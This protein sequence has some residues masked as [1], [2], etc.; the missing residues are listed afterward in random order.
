MHQQAGGWVTDEKNK[1]GIAIKGAYA[2]ATHP[3]TDI[4][5]CCY[6]F[7]NE[8][9]VRYWTPAM[10]IPKKL[11]EFA[12]DKGIIR[13]HNSAFEFYIWN[14]V[15]AR[16]YAWPKIR[17]E[18]MECSAAKARRFSLPGSLEK[19]SVVLSLPIKKNMQ[20]QRAMKRLC[21][22]GQNVKPTDPV[23][24]MLYNIDDVKAQKHLHNILP[25]LTT[26]ER[27]VW[28][29]DQK[30]NAN[31]VYCDRKSLNAFIGAFEKFRHDA[32]KNIRKLTRG[33]VTTTEQL[34]AL[35]TWMGYDGPITQGNINDLIGKY[36]GVVKQVLQ[37]R[38]DAS[39]AS[40]KK[41]Y[42]L[43]NR[44]CDH[45]DRVRDLF[46]FCGADRTGRFT[47]VGP[48][49]QNF[50]ASCAIK[51][52]NVD[53]VFALAEKGK[54]YDHFGDQTPEAIKGA[55][56][57]L[58]CAPEH[59]DRK[60][61]VT[62]FSSIEGVIGAEITGESW[63]RRVFNTHGKIYE[64]S[65]S[66]IT[67]VPFEQIDKK[68]PARRLGKLAELASLYGGSLG[69]W[70]N[71]GAL[72]FLN[73]SEIE[74]NVQL[75]RAAS[76]MIPKAWYGL[77][78]AAM[79]ATENP[80]IPYRYRDITYIR[81]KNVLFCVLPSKKYLSYHDPKITE[82]KFGKPALTYMGFN[83][84]IKMGAKGWIR[85]DTWGG[86]LLENI[87]QA[88]A[89]DI[90]WSALINV[91]KHIVGNIVLHVHDEICTEIKNKSITI[92]EYEGVVSMRQPWCKE[93]PIKAEGGY[94]STRFRK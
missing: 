74:K 13:A 4:L 59:L 36:D 10:P 26:Y 94:I 40:I 70:K 27:A 89:G 32:D 78:D 93:Y 86:K 34:P 21:I 20:A 49:P 17:F 38:H 41:L 80:N 45:D 22:P 42:S 87:V 58:F 84:N 61:I 8:K 47:G 50:P 46:I 5:S 91:D 88:I 63:R 14:F 39:C 44:I 11:L 51:D 16:L 30:I 43:R 53:E 77:Q 33:A 31:G 66:K 55:M 15:C 82:G 90:L 54:L 60:L 65:A 79:A 7:S 25:P 71:F 57:G 64:M 73:E 92:S 35:K 52:L 18:Q 19:L 28:L 6:Q 37:L 48:Q 81:K 75:W 83:T 69:A 2:Y 29:L 9:K 56:R 3:S 12:S 85:L 68:H 72:E 1:T 23:E 62:D 76:P 67:G 24:S